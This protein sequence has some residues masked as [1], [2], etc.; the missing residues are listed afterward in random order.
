MGEGLGLASS[1][2]VVAG[3]IAGLP[4]RTLWKPAS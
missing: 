4:E 1:A 3:T 2:D